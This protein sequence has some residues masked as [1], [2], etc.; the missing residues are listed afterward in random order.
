MLVYKL[1]PG[2][3]EKQI[4]CIPLQHIFSQ[5]TNLFWFG[6]VWY[7]Y[8]GVIVYLDIALPNYDNMGI[9]MKD[10]PQYC[11]N[12]LILA[13]LCQI[14]EEQVLNLQK[15]NPDPTLA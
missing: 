15:S 10:Q 7:C 1:Y 6:I 4:I 5:L 13:S 9:N 8:C 12:C 2:E 3:L 14:L 11:F